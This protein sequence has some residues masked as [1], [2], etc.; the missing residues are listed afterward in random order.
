MVDKTYRR[1]DKPL[2]LNG[3]RKVQLVSEMTEEDR[4]QM[5]RKKIPLLTTLEHA[6]RTVHFLYK[7]DGKTTRLKHY[8]L[9]FED[10]ATAQAF[11][12]GM[13]L[14]LKTR[15]VKVS[16]S[17]QIE[18]IQRGPAALQLVLVEEVFGTHAQNILR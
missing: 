13:L 2:P 14:L 7:Q 12:N 3:V 18:G 4:N 1:K 8:I 11:I 15:T 6:R 9:Q 16:A 5:S 10:M 17:V